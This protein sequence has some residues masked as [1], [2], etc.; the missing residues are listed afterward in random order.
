MGVQ[1]SHRQRYRGLVAKFFVASV[2]LISIVSCAEVE[3]APV[4]A[5]ESITT[6]AE[7][8]PKSVNV[9]VSTEATA[10]PPT[11]VPVAT[12]AQPEVESDE[13]VVQTPAPDA[14][15][16]PPTSVPPSASPTLSPVPQPANVSPTSTFTPTPTVISVPAPIPTETPVPAPTPTLAPTPRPIPGPISR[17]TQFVPLDEPAYVSRDQ[18]SEN[19]KNTS[20]VLGVA[21]NGEARAYPLDMMWYHH[22]A[23]DTVGGEPWLVTY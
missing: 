15:T 3:L 13:V 17:Q 11:F 12:P 16:I 23:N 10:L 6:D 7:T 2:A 18:A 20:Y 9:V 1:R 5:E 4:V 14:T 19:I 8:T 22:I 21:N